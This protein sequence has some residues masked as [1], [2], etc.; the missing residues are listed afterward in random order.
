[1]RMLFSCQKE[2]SGQTDFLCSIGNCRVGGDII[3]P[4]GDRQLTSSLDEQR[5]VPSPPAIATPPPHHLTWVAGAAWQTG[6]VTAPNLARDGDHVPTSVA[7]RTAID[8][9]G[10]DGYRKPRN[11]PLAVER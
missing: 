3:R 5:G 2:S 9:G 10:T 11:K 6:A 4:G 1:M 8:S 7:I